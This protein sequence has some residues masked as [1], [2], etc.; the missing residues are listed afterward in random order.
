MIA[1]SSFFR[2]CALP[3]PSILLDD[4]Y[5][6]VERLHAKCHGRGS[7]EVV[8][9]IMFGS[10]KNGRIPGTQPCP[11]RSKQIVVDQGIDE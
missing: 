11:Y 2:H 9:R 6:C 7:T 10:K 1:E 4:G 3:F 8:R 5:I